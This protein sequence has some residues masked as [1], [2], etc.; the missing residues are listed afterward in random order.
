MTS[1]SGSKRSPYTEAAYRYASEV[2]GAKYAPKWVRVQCASFVAYLDKKIG[3][4]NDKAVHNTCRFIEGLPPPMRDA[5]ASPR[6]VL[7]PAQVYWVAELYGR[8]NPADE[9]R[10]QYKELLLVVPRKAGKSTI[11][12][13]LCLRELCDP[14]RHGAMAQCMGR[15]KHLAIHVY[16]RARKMIAA[17]PEL[18]NKYKFKESGS[19]IRRLDA[20]SADMVVETGIARDGARPVIVTIDELHDM[21]NDRPLE[22]ARSSLGNTPNALIAKFTTAGPTRRSVGIEERQQAIDSFKGLAELP[23]QLALLYEWDDDLGDALDDGD[24]ELWRAV[25]PLYDHLIE[26]DFYPGYYARSKSS[27]KSRQEF[28]HKLLCKWR[29]ADQAQ[30]ISEEEWDALPEAPDINKAGIQR[31][32][33]GIDTAMIHDLMSIT[34]LGE[35]LDGSLCAWWRV[36]VPAARVGD[37]ALDSDDAAKD[38]MTPR[39][40]KRWIDQ[41]HMRV[42]GDT[43]INFAEMAEVITNLMRNYPVDLAVVDQYSGNEQIYSFMSEMCQMKMKR[44]FK[45]AS[46]FTPPMQEL[47]G[48]V[49]DRKIMV[50]KNPV[51]RWGVTNAI[52]DAKVAESLLPKKPTEWSKDSIDPLDSLVLA[53]AAKQCFLGGQFRPHKDAPIPIHRAEYGGRIRA[54]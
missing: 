10:R 31:A 13:A 28:D 48:R 47:L 53:F 27:D 39:A 19:H 45:R 18:R 35:L 42:S 33:V 17:S 5:G 3:P 40:I 37:D 29:R 41:G 46:N 12:A 21:Q 2:A 54:L 30:C 22:V 16:D 38:V 14:S 34:L 6:I 11:G 1:T 7:A 44:L 15:T 4:Y 20:S 25:H 43:R 36:F 24:P 9:T 8:R 32:W 23:T 26:P 49:S 50:E 51:V 52:M